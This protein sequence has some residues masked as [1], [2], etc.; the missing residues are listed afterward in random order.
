MFMDY[1]TLLRKAI[2]QKRLA[3]KDKTAENYAT[4]SRVFKQFLSEHPKLVNEQTRSKE[5]MP[6]EKINHSLIQ[7][8][9]QWLIEK[10]GCMR[11]S[12]SAYLRNLRA[13][14]NQA[15][16]D[17]ICSDS[18]PFRNVYT[19]VDTTRKRAITKKDM[20]QIMSTNLSQHP[21][22]ELSRDIFIF[23][24]IARGMAFIDI[25]KLTK[26]NIQDE[27]I[28]YTRSKTGQQISLEYSKE[29]K[30]IVKKYENPRRIRLFPII[31]DSCFDQ[32]EYESA[33][34]L[35]NSNLSR[36]SSIAGL[37][38]PITSYSARHSWAT[39]AF[40]LKIPIKIISSCMGHTS[41]RTTRI[42]LEQLKE[43][44]LDRKCRIVIR[45]YEDLLTKTICKKH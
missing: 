31:N 2:E 19:G 25:A 3:G 40:K 23:S 1:F 6:I 14:Y 8:F 41:E 38:H 11:N 18:R 17:E 12:S 34:H 36:I 39:Q 35:Y 30:R 37:S 24:F 7:S 28:I 9:E 27:R 45:Q 42:Y 16:E 32:K 44:E 21:G 22:L 33:L 43:N 26:K 29:L 13:V 5:I 4:A 10:R 20:Q 15:V